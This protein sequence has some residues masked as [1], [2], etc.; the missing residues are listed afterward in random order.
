MDKVIR[1]NRAR[2]CLIKNSWKYNIIDETLYFIL[3]AIIDNLS[4]ILIEKIADGVQNQIKE[5]RFN[6]IKFFCLENLYNRYQ[7]EK[8]IEMEVFTKFRNENWN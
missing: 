1:L 4:L 3:L 6:L 8:K 5:F 7:N 2:N